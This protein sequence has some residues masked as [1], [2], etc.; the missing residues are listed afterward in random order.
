MT[1]SN[2]T[3]TNTNSN[4]P[5]ARIR[6]GR[7]QAAIWKQPTDKGSFYT[8]TIERSYKDENENYQS[9]S[10]FS[11]QDALLVAKVANLADTQIRNLMDA[12]YAASQT[13]AVDE[14]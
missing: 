12:D 9:S 1:D 3:E 13:D 14:S 6:R 4:P 11:L 10:S 8:F 7:I 2:N 5:A